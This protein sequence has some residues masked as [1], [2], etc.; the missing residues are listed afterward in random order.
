MSDTTVG[1]GT[2][3]QPVRLRAD[4]RRDR[5]VAVALALVGGAAIFVGGTPYFELSAAND[6]PVYNA[7]LVITFWLLTRWL[8]RAQLAAWAGVAQALFVAAAAMLVLVVGP[9]NRLVTGAEGS[10]EQAL[11]DKL[12]QFLSVVPVL[13]VLTGAEGRP[14]SW[15]YLQKG[16]TKRWPACGLVSLAVGAV[17]V[18]VAAVVD[19]AGAMDLASVAPGVVAFA[20]LNATM[21]ELWFRGIFLRPFEVGM[22][23]RAA[24]AVTA[25]I[26]GAAHLAATYIAPAEQLLFTALVVGLGAILAWAMRWGNALWGAVLLH[27]GL[28]LVVALE[29]V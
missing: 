2:S 22:G 15:I 6:N 27:I 18:T 23:A 19:G 17:G 1:P 4:G 21:E 25:L 12:A 10:L 5:V 7:G 28:D 9:F 14:W 20:A 24:V 29:F 16:L 26:F 3:A 13:L 8:R 11:Q